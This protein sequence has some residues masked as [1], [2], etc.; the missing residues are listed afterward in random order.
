MENNTSV[1]IPKFSGKNFGTWKIQVIVALKSKGL[2]GALQ[3]SKMTEKQENQVLA[4]LYGAMDQTIV[5]K[6]CAQK[7]PM[8]VWERLCKIY[9]NLSPASVSKLL[10]E[11]Y[12][13][14]KSEEDDMS[15]HIAKVEAMADNLEGV[16]ETQSENSIMCQLLHTL[17]DSY[18]A[19][20]HA[21][22]SVDPDRQTRDLL[23]ERLLSLVKESEEAETGQKEVALVAKNGPKKNLKKRDKSKVKCYN[24]DKFGHYARDCR[25]KKAE[26]ESHGVAM[27]ALA[28]S[29]HLDNFIIDSGSSKHISANREWFRNYRP[30]DEKVQVGNHEWVEAVG[31]GEIELVCNIG[32]RTELVTIHD[33]LHVPSI[34]RNLFSVGAA[35]QKGAEFSASKSQCRITVSGKL[36]AIG[37]YNKASKLYVL[38]AKVKVATALLASTKRTLTEWH[39]ALGHPSKQTIVEMAKEKTVDGLEIIPPREE[40]GCST[41]PE[42]KASRAPHTKESSIKPQEVGDQIDLDLVGPMAKPSL[43]MSKYILLMRDRFSGYSH[44]YLIPSKDKVHAEIQKYLGEF[45]SESGRR[46]KRI[47]T[48]N[49]SEFSNE[50]VKTLCELEHVKLDFVAPYTPEQNGAA[51]RNNRTIVE[52]ATVMI[53][54]SGLEYEIWG[55]AVA[56]AVYLRNR[57]RKKNNKLTPYEYFTGRKPSVAHI[58]PFG[59]QVHSLITDR[60]LGKFEAKTERGFVVGFTNRSNTYRIY[61]PEKRKV[62]I[63]C[64]V[65][66]RPHKSIG[67]TKVEASP[68][69][70]TRVIEMQDKGVDEDTP[71]PG[72]TQEQVSSETDQEEIES[73]SFSTVTNFEVADEEPRV[74]TGNRLQRFF[75][76]FIRENDSYESISYAMAAIAQ[77]EP[78]TYKQAVECSE[79][80]SWKAAIRDELEAHKSN[81]TWRVVKR[82]Q[83]ISTLRVKWVFRTKRDESGTIERFKARLVAKGFDQRQGVDYFE[84][85]APVARMESIRIL[86]A[87]AAA[88]GL[89]FER[90][91][92]STA[93]LN[94]VIEEQIFIE[95]PE[96]LSIKND[97]CLKLERALYGLK[98]SPKVWNS[99]FDKCIRELGFEALASEPCLYREKTGER[100]VALYVDDG[101]VIGPT[102]EE[103]IQLIKNLNKFFKTNRVDSKIFLGMEINR[104]RDGIHLSQGRF[105]LDMLERFKMSQ[106]GCL[107]R[108]ISDTKDLLEKDEAEDRVDIPYRAAIGCLQY[109]AQATR[110][111]ILFAAIFLSRFSEH[112][113]SKH[114]SAVKKV[115]MYLKGTK[116]LGLFMQRSKGSITIE[117]YSDADYANDPDGRRST[118]GILVLL[119][120]NPVVFVSRKQATVSV[121]SSEGELVAACEA[122]RELKWI[123]MLLTELGIKFERPHLFVDNR[124]TIDMIRNNDI[125]R[126]SKHI[127]VKYWYIRQA[128]QEKLFDIEWVATKEQKADYLTKAIPGIQLQKLLIVSNVRNRSTRVD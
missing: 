4:L 114:W 113:K 101:L 98:Q 26:E 38:D 108:P 84:T 2:M 99:T 80:E 54:Q 125:S 42:G 109:C 96:G 87:L 16:G 115:M 72:A 27:M 15:T 76:R 95:A 127:D 25:S 66:F 106:A 119:C 124:S 65:I 90:F 52:T 77:E 83:G 51:E 12:Q 70:T 8:K 19:L 1:S 122:A 75:D 105:I 55:E 30:C 104:S 64:D 94:G 49:G 92:V 24:C 13:Y 61:I 67:L 123:T 107:S 89:E 118:S 81:G 32:G 56:T 62:K 103:C 46:I 74:C 85:F 121:S 28:R 68:Q 53:A 97:E 36:Y 100:V 102:K 31:C 21:W 20:K 116:D 44:S 93:F 9:Q 63:S 14:K 128:L 111:D 69:M 22:D 47:T 126:R 73:P 110:P 11:W 48:D 41:C 120:G 29:S 3:G 57:I 58:V 45:E 17:P 18:E 6:V 112:P 40:E 23:T 88:K 33:V 86:F 79:K 7:T 10:A 60:K 71:E 82:P 50:K 91:D 37:H 5:A 39:Q 43:G 34:A 117:A 59:T 78:Q 35:T